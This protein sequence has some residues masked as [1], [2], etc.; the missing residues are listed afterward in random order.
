MP[1]RNV[2]PVLSR[3]PDVII[4]GSGAG[5][6]PMARSLT[7]R[8]LEVLLL[9]RGRF[10]PR[11]PENADVDEVFLRL[12]Y[13]PE[14]RWYDRSG[15]PYRPKPWYNIGGATKFF[16]TVMVRFRESDFREVRHADGVSPA[17]P[18][19]YVQME[20]WYHKAE[21]LFG[22]H[23]DTEADPFD[24]PRSGPLPYGPVG[25]E[26]FVEKIHRKVRGKGLHPFSMPVAVD[27]HK[28]G[29]CRRCSTCDGFPCPYGAKN[30]AETRCVEPAMASGRL[31]LW[32]G[33]EVQRLLLDERTRKINA[34]EVKVDGE[35]RSVTAPVVV[36]AAGSINSPRILFQSA[37]SSMPR[38]LANSSDLVG[39]NYM[40]H[41]LTM[42]MAVGPSVNPT[43]F[44]KTFA[45][46]DWYDGDNRFPYPMGNVQTLGRLQP[47]MLV[48]GAKFLPRWIGRQ[49]TRRS[50][51]ILTTSEDLPD[52]QNRVMLDGGK[53]RVLIEPTNMRAH[54]EL[55]RRTR[56]LMRSIGLPLVIWKTLPANLTA[57]P[58]GTIRMGHTPEEAPLSEWCQSFD[59]PNLYVVDGSFM[60]SSSAQNPS[61][62]IIAQSLRV[63]DRIA[64][65]E[66][67]LGADVSD[68]QIYSNPAV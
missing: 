54:R 23:G 51:D 3:S 2:S 55:N 39:R 47:G 44:Q 50:F 17:W 26:P 36:L 30:D 22:A 52:P 61:L 4:I 45:F 53:L 34:V 14:E 19:S 48:A 31:T 28:G 64:R 33:T 1:A 20:P 66:F 43:K 59:H 68:A 6:G 15:R 5:G 10:V 63:A 57:C 32:T 58:L 67:G 27:L 25:S 49:L 65:T 42:M 24:P 56:A 12:R 13:T 18:V 37:T 41:N 21:Q 40:V 8:G 7:A 9:E 29:R 46:N 62:T 11:E 60:P 35:L 38:G 16:G